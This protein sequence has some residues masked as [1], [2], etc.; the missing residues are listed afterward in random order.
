MLEA[1]ILVVDGVHPVAGFFRRMFEPTSFVV[2]YAGTGVEAM[3]FMGE[4]PV[5][6]LITDVHIPGMNGRKLAAWVQEHFPYT[7]I[8]LMSGYSKHGVEASLEEVGGLLLLRKPLCSPAVVLDCIHMAL[9][10]QLVA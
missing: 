3:E 9:E 1:R 2:D 4:Q 6:L 10:R 5:N 7:G 8:V